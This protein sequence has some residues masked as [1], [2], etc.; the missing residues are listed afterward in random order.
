[1]LV[2]FD[3]RTIRS[4]REFIRALGSKSPGD[5]VGVAI[6]RDGQLIETSVILEAR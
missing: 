2:S 5:E 4:L 3:G 1:V 6:L